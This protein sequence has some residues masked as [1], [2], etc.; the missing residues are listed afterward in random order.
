MIK[1]MMMIADGGYCCS[2]GAPPRV[3]GVASRVHHV[4]H[5]LRHRIGQRLAVSLLSVP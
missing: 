4:L 2:G 1:M 3:M 5:E